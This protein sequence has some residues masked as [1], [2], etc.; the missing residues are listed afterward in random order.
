VGFVT[1]YGQYIRWIRGISPKKHYGRTGQLE[2]DTLSFTFSSH[3][4]FLPPHFLLLDTSLMHRTSID[5]TGIATELRSEW[6]L[7]KPITTLAYCPRMKPSV[8]SFGLSKR[9]AGGRSLH[10][11]RGR[12]LRRFVVDLRI[13]FDDSSLI[14]FQRILTCTIIITLDIVLISP[15]LVDGA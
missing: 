10:N 9:G 1:I 12:Q 11:V 6:Q 14:Y 4:S 8:P 2:R 7:W 5:A 3:P 15:S 13:S